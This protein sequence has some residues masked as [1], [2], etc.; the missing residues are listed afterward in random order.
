MWICVFYHQRIK[1][2][3]IIVI[4]K[5][6]NSSYNVVFSIRQLICT[7]FIKRKIGGNII[8]KRTNK[9]NTQATVTVVLICFPL[10]VW[11]D[12]YTNSSFD[13][14]LE[15]VILLMK[16]LNWWR[17]DLYLNIGIYFSYS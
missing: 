4:K 12:T 6:A 5:C 16:Y 17:Q 3:A 7:L 13:G 9:K 10:V 2:N 14:S 1:V 8:N 15:N 11:N